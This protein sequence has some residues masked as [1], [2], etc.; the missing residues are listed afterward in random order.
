MKMRSPSRPGF[1]RSFLKGNTPLGALP[2]AELELL[3]RKGCAR[4]FAKGD[5]IYRRGEPGDS[6]MVSLSARVKV[7]NVN[8]DAS[9]VVLAFQDPGDIIREIA[10][11]HKNPHSH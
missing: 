2:E 5:V 8:D 11:L 6:L 10:V 7:T 1:I 4:T 9:E 3:V